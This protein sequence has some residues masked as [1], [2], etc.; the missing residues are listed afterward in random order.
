MSCGGDVGCSTS[1]LIILVLDG[2]DIPSDVDVVQGCCGSSEQG[3]GSVDVNRLLTRY[4]DGESSAAERLELVVWL[5]VLSG[6]L[7]DVHGDGVP[8]SDV[9]VVSMGE[10]TGVFWVATDTIVG[11][12]LTT[13]TIE[14]SALVLAEVVLRQAF[15]LPQRPL[16]S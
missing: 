5:T 1:S 7:F 16:T 13:G 11:F 14:G 12:C 8:S 6:S 15:F 10:M 9:V 2:S 4:I 3:G